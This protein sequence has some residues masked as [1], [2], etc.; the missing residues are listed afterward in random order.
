MITFNKLNHDNLDC[1]VQDKTHSEIQ[2]I[3]RMREEILRKIRLAG[4]TGNTDE[5]RKH[6]EKLATAC[7]I[8]RTKVHD[9]LRITGKREGAGL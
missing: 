1:F 9:P 8:R 5:V 2:K 4:Y 7:A 3:E 6:S